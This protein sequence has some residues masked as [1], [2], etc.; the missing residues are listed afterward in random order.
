MLC[1]IAQHFPLSAATLESE[2]QCPLGSLFI[3]I[4]H[5]F[6]GSFIALFHRG[7]IWRNGWRRG[8]CKGSTMTIP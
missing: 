8:S 2:L 4:P 6:F 7:V 5:L 3:L 1:H